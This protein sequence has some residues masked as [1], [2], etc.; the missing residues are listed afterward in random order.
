MLDK[1]ILTFI[2]LVETGSLTAAAAN[3]RI[4]KSVVGQHLKKLEDQYRMKLTTRTTRSLQPT[5]EG[6]KFYQKCKELQEISGGIL[7]A[8]GAEAKNPVGLVSIGAPSGIL[9]KKISPIAMD[10]AKR[11]PILR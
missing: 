4:S 8:L 6:G 7:H 11:F 9:E 1:K 10:L 2:S 5:L 3:L